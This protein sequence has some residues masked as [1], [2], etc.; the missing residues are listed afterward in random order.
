M[1]MHGWVISNACPMRLVDVL[2][3]CSSPLIT[4]LTKG[5]TAT[6]EMW[7]ESSLAKRGTWNSLS[8]LR[9]LDVVPWTLFRCSGQHVQRVP[10]DTSSLLNTAVTIAGGAVVSIYLQ[11]ICFIWFVIFYNLSSW[12]WHAL[13]SLYYMMNEQCV[14]LSARIGTPAAEGGGGGNIELSFSIITRLQ[15]VL[16]NL[17]VK[18]RQSLILRYLEFSWIVVG[19][20]PE[21]QRAVWGFSLYIHV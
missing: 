8:V 5:I 19:R 1:T 11:F 4:P 14:W 18:L 3:C 15:E 9:R 20:P 7:G 2:D 13:C 10:G 16:Q 6:K 21:D 17:I 12:S